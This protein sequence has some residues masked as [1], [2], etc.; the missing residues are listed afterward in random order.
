M[1]FQNAMSALNPVFRISDQLVDVV[2]LHEA[3]SAD[4]ARARI[5]ELFDRVG[6][7][8][9]RIDSYPHEFSGGMRQRAIIA[10]SLICRPDL[11]IAD[12]PTTALDVVAQAQVLNQ[13]R[14]LRRALDLS[15][16]LV[17]HDI[18]VVGE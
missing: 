1:I 9:S 10:L 16:I 5:A 15:L 7:P 2:R 4:E 13:L 6:I 17:T 8:G 3:V 14:E 18:M 12:E 11:V